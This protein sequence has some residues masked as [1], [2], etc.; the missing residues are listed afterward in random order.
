VAKKKKREKGCALNDA[1]AVGVQAELVAGAK[2]KKAKTAKKKA[3]KPMIAS[4]N[5][6]LTASGSDPEARWDDEK[7]ELV[8][9]IPAPERG[10]RGPIGPTGARGETGAAG[11]QGP[12]GPQGPAGAKG[13][14][15]ARGERGLDGSPGL[16]GV[17]G[18]QGPQG[19]QGT[20]GPKGAPGAGILYAAAGD[21]ARRFLRVEADGSLV[22]LRDGVKYALTLEP[23]ATAAAGD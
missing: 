4:V 23:L 13:E 22:Y 9:A 14:N 6:S 2:D 1:E 20:P 3:D 11:T 10:E 7:R 8:L 17:Q 18:P 5:L 21:E 19:L 16:Q 12:Q 15:G